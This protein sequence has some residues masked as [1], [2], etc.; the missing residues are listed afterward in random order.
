MQ[1]EEFERGKKRNENVKIAQISL[2]KFP[3]EL[4]INDYLDQ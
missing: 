1:Y 2:Q 3:D 4:K